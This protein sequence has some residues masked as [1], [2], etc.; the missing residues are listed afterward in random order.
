MAR[1]VVGQDQNVLN[2]V[3][4]K[5][6]GQAKRPAPNRQG[7]IINRDLHLFPIDQIHEEVEQPRIAE[8]PLAAENGQRQP[9]PAKT[10]Q[11]HVERAL[12][13]DFAQAGDR[14]RE[15]RNDTVAEFEEDI[16]VRIG[17]DFGAVSSPESRGSLHAVGR[18]T[19]A[20]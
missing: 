19:R 16:G 7:F 20:G 10:F 15:A 2:A 3:P 9:P 12:L 1:L 5:P 14:I 13:D 17:R 8:Q 11:R 4:R 6:F 18:N